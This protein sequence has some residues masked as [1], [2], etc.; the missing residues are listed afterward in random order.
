VFTPEETTIDSSIT[1]ASGRHKAEKQVVLP[2]QIAASKPRQ[3][4]FESKDEKIISLIVSSADYTT[5]TSAV[6]KDG[7]A[8]PA[9]H[10]K[11]TGVR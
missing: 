5:G 6:H 9:R 2:H 10:E 1:V 3:E 11:Q 8:R 4:G 7:K